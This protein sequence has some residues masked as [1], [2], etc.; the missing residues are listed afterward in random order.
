MVIDPELRT[1]AKAKGSST[2]S[3]LLEIA[4]RPVAPPKRLGWQAPKSNAER[5]PSVDDSSFDG[6]LEALSEL[7]LVAEPVVLKPAGTVVVELTGKQ[8]AAVMDLPM[9]AAIR[10]NRTHRVPGRGSR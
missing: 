8:L 5:S 2:R 9:V 1:F 7:D 4:S 3:I 6:L 10:P